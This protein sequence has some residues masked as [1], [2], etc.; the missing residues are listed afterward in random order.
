[1]ESRKDLLEYNQ[2]LNLLHLYL[3]FHLRIH[4]NIAFLVKERFFN[5]KFIR[6]LVTGLT[7]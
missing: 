5:K 4:L 7:M 6:V 1:M 2:N 3:N